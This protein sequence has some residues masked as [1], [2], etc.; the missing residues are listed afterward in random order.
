MSTSEYLVTTSDNH[1]VLACPLSDWHGTEDIPEEL[2]MYS[3]RNG[4]TIVVKRVPRGVVSYAGRTE[5]QQFKNHVLDIVQNRF[6][7][8][9]HNEEGVVSLPNE[10]V[11]LTERCILTPFSTSANL[12]V[13]ITSLAELADFIAH[14][15]ILEALYHYVGME[16]NVS[17]LTAVASGMSLVEGMWL[18]VTTVAGDTQIMRIDRKIHSACFAVTFFGSP[19]GGHSYSVGEPVKRRV[20]WRTRG[21]A[22]RQEQDIA[23]G[24]IR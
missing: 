2:G 20:K 7:A 21:P 4:D 23:I 5:A 18:P 15:S 12:N 14:M 19:K 10:P 9:A 1:G 24:E 8:T 13:Y 17:Q 16:S 6:P 3:D 11:V 22:E